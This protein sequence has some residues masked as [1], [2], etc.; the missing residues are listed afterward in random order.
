MYARF[1]TAPMKEG[2]FKL[3]AQTLDKEVIPLLKKQPGFKD[4]L[5]FFDHDKGEAIAISFWDSKPH[6]EKYDRDV[7]PEVKQSMEKAFKG[8]P[9]IRTLEVFNSTA[10]DIHPM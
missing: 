9:V 6:V 8:Q 3:V 7:Y 1:I 2:D 10:Y 5:A 4:E